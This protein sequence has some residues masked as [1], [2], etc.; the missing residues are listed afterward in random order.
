MMHDNDGS[1][2]YWRDT[3]AEALGKMNRPPPD[4]TLEPDEKNLKAV[5]THLSK[6]M[7]NMRVYLESFPV[8]RVAPSPTHPSITSPAT[9]EKIVDERLAYCRRILLA[10]NEEYSRNGDRLHNFRSAAR[11]RD[12]DPMTALL[13]MKV[14]HDVSID[15][16]VLDCLEGKPVHLDRLAEKMT[17]SINYLLLLEALIREQQA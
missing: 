16:L 14:K 3:A 8:P 12:T 2:V 1:K 6:E 10:K 17:D 9:F 7:L 11:I 5:L 15:D 4:P 13:G